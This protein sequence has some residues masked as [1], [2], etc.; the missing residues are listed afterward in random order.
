MIGAAES[1]NSRAYYIAGSVGYIGPTVDCRII[2]TDST[3]AGEVGLEV[4][5]DRRFI[6]HLKSLAV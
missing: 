3:V 2:K 5:L 6:L 1:R 4:A